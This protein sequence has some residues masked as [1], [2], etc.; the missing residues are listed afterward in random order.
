MTQLLDGLAGPDLPAQAWTAL[1][2]GAA[3]RLIGEVRA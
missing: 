3:R 1:T 2:G